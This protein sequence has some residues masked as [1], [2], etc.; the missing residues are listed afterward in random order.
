[1]ESIN[2]SWGR[3]AYN[4]REGTGPSL[5]FLHGTGC[6]ADDWRGVIG[7]LPAGIDCTCIDFRGHGRSDV[8]A[9]DFQ[10]SD[11]THD[12]RL[13]LEIL[14]LDRPI[15]VGHSL[16]GMVAIDVAGLR[17]VAGL[18]LLEGWTS[19]SVVTSAFERGQRFGQLG[20]PRIEEIEQKR[21]ETLARFGGDQWRGFWQTV[22]EFDG[23]EILARLDIPIIEVFGTHWAKERTP[24]ALGIP[25]RPNIRVEWI[26][27]CG[28]FL[29]HEAPEGVASI[30]VSARDAC[31]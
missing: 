15:L 7:R 14:D 18:V 21:D 26:D 9:E 23:S 10:F 8:P 31:A 13:A 24:S 30:C 4:R 1:M 11:F 12:V 20:A 5:V 17:D 19:L 29:P 3:L 27:G 22:G 25:D 16:G 28:H 2:T 6:D